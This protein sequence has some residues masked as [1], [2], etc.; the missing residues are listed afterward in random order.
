[1]KDMLNRALAPGDHV[2][3][4]RIKSGCMYPQ[5]GTVIES[6]NKQDD[7]HYLRKGTW[8]LVQFYDRQSLVKDYNLSKL[9]PC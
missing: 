3:H 6:S 9:A 2:V 4:I 8:V 5:Q 7:V 1:M